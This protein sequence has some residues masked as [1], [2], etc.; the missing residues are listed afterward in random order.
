MNRKKRNLII[1]SGI[2]NIFYAALT[3]T[4]TILVRIFPEFFQQ[5]NPYLYFVGYST[6]L[7][8]GIVVFTVSIIGSILLFHSV[9]E[10]GK[11]Y[12]GSYG[13]YVT[14]MIIVVF[15][16][17]WISWILLIFAAFT[18]DIIIINDTEDLRQQEREEIVR[19]KAYEEKKAKIEELKKLR[20]S[21]T[22]SEEEYK[23]KLFELL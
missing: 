8:Y 20:D 18:P 7:I 23:E 13:V 4:M 3:L 10:K 11:Y 12:R 22:I 2:V 5:Y 1:A 9:R 15:T 16:G 17:G 19:D 14:G 21:G 6:N